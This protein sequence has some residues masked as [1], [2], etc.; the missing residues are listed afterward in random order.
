MG[1]VLFCVE[2]VYQLFN[3]ITLCLEKCQ[4]K[5]C[6][7]IMS[8]LTIWEEDM[9]HRMEEKGIFS[10]IIRPLTKETEDNF[11]TLEIEEK[12]RAVDEPTYFFM[13]GKVP[14][15]PIY[16]ELY[17]PIDHIYW[18]MIYRCH[19]VNGVKP[20]IFMYDEG[21]RAYTMELYKTDEQEYFKG[22]YAKAPF[23]NGIAAYYLYRPEWYYV[24]EYDYELLQ[25]PN[26]SENVDL[27][28]VL[29]Y[30]FGN[31][32]VP[33][34]KYIYMED[35]YYANDLKT[36]D[37]EVFCDIAKLVGKENIIVKRHPRGKSDRFGGAGYSVTPQSVVPWEAQ[38][39][40]NDISKKILI[41]FSST[42]SLSPF[43]IFDMDMHIISLK[44]MLIS[45]NPLIIDTGFED[46]FHSMIKKINNKKVRIHMPN[47]IDEF[48]EVIR[49]IGFLERKE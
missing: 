8:N 30:I 1:R 48:A 14:I 33:K 9:I 25:L 40:G 5:K 43:I 45:H 21:L 41:S 39:L 17:V 32:D 46:F 26:P 2:S 20:T 22:D 4:D 16:D 24:K 19:I 23:Y 28:K 3:S 37:Y 11:R 13:D 7:L 6:D 18:K 27:K 34:E 42:S 31:L 49:Y 29:L 12:I 38:L 36:N 47:N 10:K 15:D 35:F 44:N